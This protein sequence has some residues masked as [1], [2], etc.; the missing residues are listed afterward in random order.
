MNTKMKSIG[1]LIFMLLLGGVVGFFLKSILIQKDFKRIHELRN[2]GGFEVVAKDIIKPTLEQNEKLDP[3]LRKH[4]ENYGNLR[5]S[6]WS[7][8]ESL[9]DSLNND[10]KDILTEEQMERWQKSFLNK[11]GPPDFKHPKKRKP[12][13]DP[14]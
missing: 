5:R 13:I 9:R 8:F 12:R 1:A 3:I 10:L 14:H 6:I 7:E 11:P 2:P 4:K